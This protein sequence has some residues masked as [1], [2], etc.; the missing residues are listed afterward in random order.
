MNNKTFF[1]KF[2]WTTLQ[3]TTNYFFAWLILSILFTVYQKTIEY[4]FF[5]MQ[6]NSFLVY[7]LLRMGIPG[8]LIMIAI[9]L[10]IIKKEPIKIF[11][12]NK[13]IFIDWRWKKKYD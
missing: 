10:L 11:T 13:K 8:S 2:M 5:P 4:F 1:N 9:F 12:V 6:V 3:S 7:V